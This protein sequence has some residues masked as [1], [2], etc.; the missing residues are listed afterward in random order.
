[1]LGILF[2]T[3]VNSVLVA[4]L[5][6]SGTFL[7]TVFIL[8]STSVVL[9]LK[10]LVGNNEVILDFAAKLVISGI[11]LFTLS[12]L[13]SRSLTSFSNLL[14]NTKF[15]VS[16]FS[17]LVFSREKSNFLTVSFFTTLLNLAKSSGTVFSL[18][19]S[20]VSTLVFKAAKFV[21]NA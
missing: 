8:F 2:F 9:L 17:N 20:I 14:Y 18:S 10:V 21:F 6:V 11:F 19:V 1:M 7:S 4:N 3:L 13:S 16:I 15:E 5:L 12:I